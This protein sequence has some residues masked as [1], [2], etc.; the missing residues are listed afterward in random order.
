MSTAAARTRPTSRPERLRAPA[1]PDLRVVEG[2]LDR[3]RTTQ[4][5][6]LSSAPQQAQHD[7]LLWGVALTL[8]GAAVLAAAT[9]ARRRRVATDPTLQD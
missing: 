2:E 3:L 6:S 1:R 4:P 9:A 5:V 8:S 7:R